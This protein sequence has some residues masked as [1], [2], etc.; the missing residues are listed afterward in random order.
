MP[1]FTIPKPCRGM[2]QHTDCA[3]YRAEANT[4]CKYCGRPIGHVLEVLRLDDD[5]LAHFKCHSAAID[6]EHE[7]RINA[8]VAAVRQ[9]AEQHRHE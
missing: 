6:A 3:V 4:D 8:A 7:A 5:T 9:V 2:C 1:P